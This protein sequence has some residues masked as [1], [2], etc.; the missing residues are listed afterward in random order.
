MT[1]LKHDNCLNR[2]KNNKTS[3][4]RISD[5]SSSFD[6]V[7]CDKQI[8][9]NN[10]FCFSF[11]SE[12]LHTRSSISSVCA[13]SFTVCAALWQK[14]LA[15]IYHLLVNRN[16][17]CKLN[18][19]LAEVMLGE[20]RQA[21]QMYNTESQRVLDSIAFGR[22]ALPP[23][24]GR[25]DINKKTSSKSATLALQFQHLKHRTNRFNGS[26]SLQVNMAQGVQS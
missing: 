16:T 14:R 8:R 11:I 22:R 1:A 26:V 21:L 3:L 9:H 2:E 20:R 13:S 6:C 12:P 7:L 15:S 10:P 5:A 19:L 17:I 4:I 23:P 24:A 18:V 25:T